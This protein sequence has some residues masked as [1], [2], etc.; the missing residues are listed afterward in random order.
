[1]GS[2]RRRP[3]VTAPRRARASTTFTDNLTGPNVRLDHYQVRRYDAWYRHATPL[4]LA[5]AFLQVTRRSKGAPAPEDNFP[6]RPGS[7]ITSALPR[8]QQMT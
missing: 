7:M 1:M 4:M 2:L 5:L 3:G 8:R 6:G